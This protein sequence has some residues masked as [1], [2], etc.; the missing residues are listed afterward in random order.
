MFL[1]QPA[2]HDV[3][4]EYITPKHNLHIVN[5]NLLE[6]YGSS[7]FRSQRHKRSF[8]GFVIFP[9]HMSTIGRKVTSLIEQE[10]FAIDLSCLNCFDQI[11]YSGD[12]LSQSIQS[13]GV[14]ATIKPFILPCV[15]KI[16]IDCH[17]LGYIVATLTADN[18]WIVKPM[19]DQHDDQRENTPFDF[20]AYE[21]ELGFYL[22]DWLNLKE[23]H[24]FKPFRDDLFQ[25]C[26]YAHTKRIVDGLK[27]NMTNSHHLKI[28]EICNDGLSEIE[29]IKKSLLF[30]KNV[31][32]RPRQ[33][34]RNL[35]VDFSAHLHLED[36]GSSE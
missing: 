1:D 15:Q 3:L 30:L 31:D 17:W 22:T 34:S 9:A 35:I 28:Q 33:S 6:I 16:Y 32:T 12:R 23:V 21:E 36:H 26:L 25:N 5:A 8:E 27:A 24:L 14:F 11:V 19:Y 2:I 10:C 13:N 4:V 18:K 7:F 29:G 20:E